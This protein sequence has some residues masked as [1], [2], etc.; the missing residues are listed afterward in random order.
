MKKIISKPD[1]AL[2]TLALNISRKA[3]VIATIKYGGVFVINGDIEVELIF[4][5]NEDEFQ[6]MFDN[7]NDHW[8]FY[9]PLTKLTDIP[10]IETTVMTLL[11]VKPL[12]RDFKPIISIPI[13][14]FKRMLEK[15]LLHL[16]C[17]FTPTN[18]GKFVNY[19]LAL[20]RCQYAIEI[21]IDGRLVSTE[22]IYICLRSGK[23][24][25]DL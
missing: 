4:S 17:F 8:K 21:Y 7:R 2:M 23:G 19:V 25:E 15:G 22:Y 14:Y 5:T 20:K 1:I 10:T 18:S 6:V 24:N 9:I 16:D 11:G 3:A 12:E 13:K